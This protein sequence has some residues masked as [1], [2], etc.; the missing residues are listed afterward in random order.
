VAT[1]EQLKAARAGR[2]RR[3]MIDAERE[4][5]LDWRDSGRLPDASL[6]VLQRELDHEES[7]L[8]R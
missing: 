1:T 7:L 4:S 2:L 6:R 8:P 5:L 3:A